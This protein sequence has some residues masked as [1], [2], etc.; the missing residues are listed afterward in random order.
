MTIEIMDDSDIKEKQKQIASYT[1]KTLRDH[2]GKGP[3]SVY[4][5]LNSSCI[6]M[7]MRNFLSPLEQ[8]V[9][10]QEGIEAVEALRD[11]LM[12]QVLPEIKGFLMTIIDIEKFEFY[13]DWTIHSK[14][15]MIT[16]IRKENAALRENDQLPNFINTI[17]KVS[18]ISRQ[19][20]KEPNHIYIEQ[21]NP[22][23]LVVVREGILIR[24]EK[25]LI[26][27]GHEQTLQI[28]K[29]RL[30]K[31]LLEDG[32]FDKILGVNVHDIFVNWDFYLDK[33]VIVFITD[34]ISL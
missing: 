14:S 10:N 32:E 22:R 19:A 28:A 12:K 5:S 13:F 23:T 11:T 17:E 30:E 34:P 3:E 7:Y 8:V 27:L 9:M 31:S 2:F 15:G 16:G 29:R 21:V 33:S 18:E 24:I 26:A 1:G 4:V 20:E 6:V 25:E